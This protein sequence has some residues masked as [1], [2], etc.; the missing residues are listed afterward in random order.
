MANVD[1]GTNEKKL[2][3]LVNVIYEHKRLTAKEADAAKEQY[4][5][6]FE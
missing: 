6:F 4:D 3:S 5:F 1:A 2:D